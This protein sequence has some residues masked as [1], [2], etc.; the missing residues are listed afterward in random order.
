M[1]KLKAFL[2]LTVF[3]VI[4]QNVSLAQNNV[5]YKLRDVKTIYLDED[6]FKFSSSSCM[7]TYGK[8]NVVCSKHWANRA[9]FLVA[10]K[11]WLGKYNFVV[12]ADKQN[13]DAILQ[14]NL[15]IDDDY[16]TQEF[17]E[18]MRKRKKGDKNDPNESPSMFPSGVLPGEAVWTVNGWLLNQDGDKLWTSPFQDPPVFSVSGKPSKVEG[19]RL[20]KK[21]Q[22]DFKKSK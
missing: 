14:G 10:L 16:S 4:C 9:A 3:F 8:L 21:L 18:R 12:T 5:I 6:S 13:S 7:Q 11:R 2:F 20:A 22:Y 17:N 15:S 1:R 19:K